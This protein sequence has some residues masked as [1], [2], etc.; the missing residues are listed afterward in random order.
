MLCKLGNNRGTGFDPSYE[1]DRLELDDDIQM[2]FVK[3]YY[4]ERYEGQNCDFITCRHVLEHIEQPVPF[5]KSIRKTLSANPDAVVMFEV[6]NVF[7]TLRDL[8]IWDIIYEHCSYFCA[9]SLSEVFAR[10]DFEVLDVTPTFNEQ[11][12]VIEAKPAASNGHTRPDVQ[13]YLTQAKAYVPEFSKNYK[14][15]LNSYRSNF[16]NFS[17]AGKKVVLWGS[18]SKG[19]TFL[20]VLGEQNVV[21]YIVDINPHKQGKYVPGTGQKIISPDYLKEFRPDI[22]IVMNS[23]YVDEIKNMIQDMDLSPQIYVDA[24]ELSLI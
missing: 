17:A 10:A 7:F 20:N 5:L 22:V 19:V 4:D 6:P 12:L 21:D 1:E 11:F 3:D 14:K 8:A 13:E 24:A 23:I 9:A 16:E 15:K 18:G 2:T